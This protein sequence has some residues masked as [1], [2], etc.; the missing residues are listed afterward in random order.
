MELINSP[1]AGGVI[2]S[3]CTLLAVLIR[4][5]IQRPTIE[6]EADKIQVDTWG[7][8]LGFANT[9]ITELAERVA[10]LE[11]ELLEAK[12]REED[13]EERYNELLKSYNNLE[14]RLNRLEG[15][16]SHFTA[17]GNGYDVQPD[18]KK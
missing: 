6:A 17:G 2:G 3:V 12:K 14:S 1:I 8:T 9:T 18:N 11:K 7:K 16:R 5:L 15:Q 13:C 4:N 10:K